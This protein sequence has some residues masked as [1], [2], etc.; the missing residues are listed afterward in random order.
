MYA[1]NLSS[2]GRDEVSM[3][4][5][6]L[7][8]GAILVCAVLFLIAE[9]HRLIPQIESKNKRVGSTYWGVYKG[10][11]SEEAEGEQT[12]ELQ[13]VARKGHYAAGSITYSQGRGVS[14]NGRK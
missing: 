11:P 1:A 6:T 9:P 13:Q 10:A 12:V 14:M 7:L 5:T 8:F 4:V 3:E 2:T